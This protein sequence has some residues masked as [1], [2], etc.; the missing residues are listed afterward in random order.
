MKRILYIILS[1]MALCASAQTQDSIKMPE[2]PFEYPL[3]PD[4]ITS[5]QGKTSY[6]MLRFWDKADMKKLMSDTVKFRKAFHDYVSF[7]PFAHVDSIK[8]SAHALTSQFSNDPK[9]LLLIAQMAEKELFGPEADF[10]SEEPYMLFIRPLLTNKKVKNQDKAR[11]L[12]QLKMLN[13]S[14]IGSNI[15]PFSYITRHGAEHSLYDQKGDYILVLFQ[16]ENCADCPMMRLRLEADIATGNVIKDGRLK[17]VIINPGKDTPEWRSAMANYPFAWEIGS[18]EKVGEEV[19]LRMMPNSYLLD[20]EYK[21][22]L[23]NIDLNQI[24]SLTSALN[25]QPKKAEP[26]TDVAE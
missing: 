20:N 23:K 9:A 24:L 12:S 22:I 7:I 14:Q 18:A 21:I 4:S 15:A 25:Q 16:D 11:Y 3:A 19:D 26:K 17:L 6:V 8:K 1:F 5:L 10:W 2:T 13:A